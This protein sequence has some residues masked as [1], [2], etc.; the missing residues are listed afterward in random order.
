MIK[1]KLFKIISSV[2]ILSSLVMTFNNNFSYA[3]SMD[4]EKYYYKGIEYATGIS[5]LC[6]GNPAIQENGAATIAV[7]SSVNYGGSSGKARIKTYTR[8]GIVQQWYSRNYKG[9]GKGDLYTHYA[10]IVRNEKI[11]TTFTSQSPVTNFITP[12]AVLPKVSS[13]TAIPALGWLVEGLK[14]PYLGAF[15]DLTLSIIQSGPGSVEH[16]I[17]ASNSSATIYLRNVASNKTEIPPSVGVANADKYTAGVYDK[18]TGSYKPGYEPKSIGAV[19]HFLYNYYIPAGQI[20]NL[21]AEAKA[22]YDIVMNNELSS[23]YRVSVYTRPAT[24]YFTIT[25]K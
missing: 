10:T 18:T 1:R 5:E 6:C 8:N 12:S 24:H 17:D 19:S 15:V 7:S 9:P 16:V 20:R 3:V 21:K 22:Y 14:V 13:T 23:A 25:G 11:A 4:S 2:A